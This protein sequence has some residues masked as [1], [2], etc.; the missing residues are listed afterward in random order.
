[1]T[2]VFQNRLTKTVDKKDQGSFRYRA[3]NFIADVKRQ[4][5][6]EADIAKQTIKPEYAQ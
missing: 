3:L 5:I 2:V 1:M 4:L 6:N